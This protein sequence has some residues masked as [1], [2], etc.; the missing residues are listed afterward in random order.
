[1]R[2]GV[3]SGALILLAALGAYRST[4]EEKA[5][6]KAGVVKTPFGKTKDGKGVDLYVLTN[7]NGV[8]AKVMTLGATITEL[9]VPDKE[10][11]LADVNL[12]FD[13]VKGFEGK[14]NPFFGCIVGRV[15]NR[16]ARGR[17]TL[18]GTEYKLAVNNPPNH[19]HGGNK[20]FDKKVWEKVDQGSGPKGVYV[21]FRYTSPDGE[22]G[23]PG[24]LSTEVRYDLTA[25]NELIITYQA[26][27]D[28]A[29]PVNLTNHAYFNLAGHNAG[30]VLGHELT[31]KAA[32]YTVTDDTLIPTG[33]IAEVKG[34]PFD[35]TKPTKIGARIGKLKKTSGYDL[36]YVLDSGGGEKPAPA[37]TVYEPGSGRVMEVLTTEPG[38]QLYTANGLDGTVKGKGGAAYKKHAG[39]CLETQHF[40]D[41]V[42]HKEFPS[43]ILRPGTTYRQTTVH[44]FSTK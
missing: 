41:A 4:A 1:M 26:T 34:T 2:K 40:P 20:G 32:K 16:I 42:N 38:V 5:K 7:K 17:F 33:K 13:D 36:N 18:D 44:R 23:Y 22:E 35:F 28:K 30:N 8:T 11:K 19:L 39:F 31:V 3:V 10:G 24:K 29:T 12:G 15:A 25:D 21:K 9:W 6:A 27:T 37:A 14:G 43:V